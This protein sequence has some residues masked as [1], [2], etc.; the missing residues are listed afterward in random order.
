MLVGVKWVVN[1]SFDFL[2][3]K[4]TYSTVNVDDL[5]Q[6]SSVLPLANNFKN[7]SFLVVHGTGD[8][9]LKQIFCS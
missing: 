7:E 1:C 3:F 5:L 8:G 2:N 4:N 9:E 6:I